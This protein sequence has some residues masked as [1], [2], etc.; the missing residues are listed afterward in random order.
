MSALDRLRA[1]RHA[2]DRP[3]EECYWPGPKTMDSASRAE[4]LVGRSDDAEE[5]ASLVQT[6]NVV[7]LSGDSGVGKSSMLGMKI[8]PALYERGFAIGMLRKFPPVPPRAD[9][10]PA[11]VSDVSRAIRAALGDEDAIQRRDVRVSEAALSEIPED[12]DLI[13]WLDDRYGKNAL[14]I[15]DQFEEVIRQ[16]PDLFDAI[17]SWIDSVVAR[18]G[19][20]ILISLRAE[21]ASRLRNLVVGAFQRADVHI[22]PLQGEGPITEVIRRGRLPQDVLAEGSTHDEPRYKPSRDGSTPVIDEDAVTLL[23]E[24]WKSAGGDD[25]T[26]QITLLHLQAVLFVLWRRGASGERIGVAEV[27]ALVREAAHAPRGGRARAN[28]A[29]T[30]RAEANRFFNWALSQVLDLHFDACADAMGLLDPSGSEDLPLKYGTRATLA[31]IAPLLSSGGYKI[32]QDLADLAHAT[33]WR[34]D[35]RFSS[36]EELL[37]WTTRR[38]D[39]AEFA[40]RLVQPLRDQD[41]GGAGRPLDQRYGP[42]DDVGSAGVLS[43]ASGAIVNFENAR[44]F[45]FAL[46]WLRSGQLGRFAFTHAGGEAVEL[47]HDG[48][49]D[50]LRRWADRNLRLPEIDV[51]S[52]RRIV[53]M[54]LAPPSWPEGVRAP[55]ERNFFDGSFAP[56]GQRLITNLAWTSCRI[57]GTHFERVIFMNCDF[58]DSKFERCTFRGVTFINCI[59]DGVAFDE[60]VIDG[61]TVQ[62]RQPGDDEAQRLPQP[63]PF[64]TVEHPDLRV[65]IDEA[66][67]LQNHYA[68]DPV[69]PAGAAIYSETSGV[70]AR[71]LPEGDER[72]R[73]VWPWT[74]QTTGLSFSGGRLSSLAFMSCVGAHGGSILL[75]QVVGTSLDFAEQSDID[76]TIVDA[77]IRGVTVSSSVLAEGRDPQRPVPHITFHS[78]RSHLEN[79][80]FSDRLEGSATFDDCAVWQLL[81][82]TPRSDVDD[83]GVVRTRGFDVDLTYS[84]FWGAVNVAT[85]RNFA[86]VSVEDSLAEVRRFAVNV[87]YRSDD[88]RAELESGRRP[89]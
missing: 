20:R 4:Q 5:I 12:E 59:L 33:L 13:A 7:V 63:P 68:R 89:E 49:G 73:Q 52:V 67:V 55:G 40:R 15:L 79:V 1:W 28:A 17:H 87:D 16:Q 74:P 22:E 43:G 53:G 54:T 47:A 70:P 41:L 2:V 26:T 65:Q 27:D 6:T 61:P 35:A 51:Y 31:R 10:M 56:G 78:E 44:E 50:A 80:W 66:V 36:D 9:G 75:R 69:E 45:Q 82:A 39:D 19:V 14:L 34:D 58:S 8:Y 85:E 11:R 48:F 37:A 18:S 72:L 30:A 3:Y 88:V 81:S 29:D 60:C 24:R 64:A 32:E 84:R 62:P 38:P 77:V 25:R 23:Y 83:A 46:E 76:I 71:A 21:Y 42:G 57:G 86:S